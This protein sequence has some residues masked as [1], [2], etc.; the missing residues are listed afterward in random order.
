MKRPLPIR[1]Q[2]LVLELDAARPPLRLLGPL[3][4]ETPRAAI[5]DEAPAGRRG[6]AR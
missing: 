4:V 1:T 3:P 2:L 5:G 6:A